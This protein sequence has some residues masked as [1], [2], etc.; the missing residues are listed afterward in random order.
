VAVNQSTNTDSPYSTAE[1]ITEELLDGLTRGGEP[2][3][4][5]PIHAFELIV[6]VTGGV[7]YKD[8][9][10][11]VRLWLDTTRMM[12]NRDWGYIKS[13]ALRRAAERLMLVEEASN[14]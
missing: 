13:V 4:F 7:T 3:E 9:D 10:Y 1:K 5:L 8:F 6:M 12:N 2:I 11:A 14:G